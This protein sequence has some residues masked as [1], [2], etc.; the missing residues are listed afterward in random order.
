MNNL[1]GAVTGEKISWI[2]GARVF[3]V[4]LPHIRKMVQIISRF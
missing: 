4:F 1:P 3:L 2:K